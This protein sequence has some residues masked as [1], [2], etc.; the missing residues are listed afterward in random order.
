[1]AQAVEKG[2]G[3]AWLYFI[4]GICQWL[5][6]QYRVNR[7]LV[8]K[9][10][11]EGRG[12]KACV[13]VLCQSGDIENLQHVWVCPAMAKEQHD[14]QTQVDLILRESFPFGKCQLE[15]R[16]SRTRRAWLKQAKALPSV[17]ILPEDRVVALTRDFWKASK[18]K[19]FIPIGSFPTAISKLLTLPNRT[20]PPICSTLLPILVEEF[21]L[22]VEG[23]TDALHHSTLFEWWCSSD[24][25]DSKFGSLGT[26]TESQLA[27][28]NIFA[29]P[30]PRES[31][32]T[33]GVISHARDLIASTCPSRVLLL[34]PNEVKHDFLVIARLHKAP[35]SAR[36][37]A[38]ST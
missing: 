34:I 20:P 17:G 9:N 28:K 11:N 12:H 26:F 36:F 14:L 5:P 29:F 23:C 13:C 1:M 27:G 6:T 16:Q 22:Q 8:D 21:R 7:H 35:I 24:P 15:S 30:D 2:D 38:G 32:E 18:H 4:F 10:R 25:M 31:L 3:R 33:I 37:S 19:E